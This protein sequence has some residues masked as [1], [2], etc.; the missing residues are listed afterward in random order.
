MKKVFAAVFK[1]NVIVIAPIHYCSFDMALKI[2]FAGTPD[3]A[4]PTLK[5]LISSEHEVIAV[6]TQP[7]RK[8]GR[9]QKML[10]SPVKQL[11]EQHQIPVEQ[12]G[13]L[14]CDHVLNTWKSYRADVVVV[15]AYGLLLPADFLSANRLGCIN[16]HVSLLPQ[17]RGAA[18]IQ[19]AI[20]NGDKQTGISIMQMDVGL[21][22]GPIWSQSV[23]DIL[24]DDTTAS[25]SDRLANEGAGQLLATLP[26]IADDKTQPMAQDN[27]H[28]SY[29]GKIQ[30]ADALLDWQLP[31]EII[32][33]QIR[34]FNPWPVA[35]TFWQNSRLRI[36][37]ASLSDAKPPNKKVG[38]VFINQQQLI[39][40]TGEGC[41][42]IE[43]LQ[44]PG[45][46]AIAA[47]DFIN[48][49]KELFA[50]QSHFFTSEEQ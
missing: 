46:K 27:S 2:I 48:A 28:S 16:I 35:Y 15:L 45:G 33:R 4:T 36:W 18:P 7:D 24:A 40:Q 29:A 43:R 22:T 25:L 37:T 5:Q 50:T 32:S 11:A 30:K 31:A 17:W 9:G 21:D 23:C 13:K 47:S 1:K 12:P 34:A 41:L 38:Q 49:Q 19:H 42:Q 44:L 26:I 10:A 6:Y 8:K 20:L 14:S 3:I 39:V